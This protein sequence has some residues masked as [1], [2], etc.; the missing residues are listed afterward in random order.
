M[1]ISFGDTE[2]ILF[3][4]KATYNSKQ[5]EIVVTSLRF[6]WLSG[7]AGDQEFQ[8]PWANIQNIKYSPADDPK[9]RVMAMIQMVAGTSTDKPPV[10]HLTGPTKQGCRIELERLKS[11]V[12][13]VRKGKTDGS[14][15]KEPSEN[16]SAA[17]PTSQAREKKRSRTQMMIDKNSSEY[18]DTVALTEKRKELLGTRPP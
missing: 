1:S 12:A 14:E 2:Q 6:A 15:S 4:N 13:A 5:G 16:S 18:K 11:T 8:T 9:E 10:F 7:N 17:D 3:K